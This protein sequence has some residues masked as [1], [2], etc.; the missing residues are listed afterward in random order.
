MYVI[1][2]N[3]SYTFIALYKS[4]HFFLS[5]IQRKNELNLAIVKIICISD[6]KKVIKYTIEILSKLVPAI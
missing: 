3:Y 6:N 4:K 2:V 1:H 5:F